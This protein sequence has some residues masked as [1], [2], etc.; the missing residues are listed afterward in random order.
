M[1][2]ATY[3]GN[4]CRNGH[5]G[6]RYKR[7]DECLECKRSHHR[8]WKSSQNGMKYNRDWARK[9]YVPSDRICLTPE[10][11]KDR[12]K[13]REKIAKSKPE[14]QIKRRETSWR[15][16][17]KER[18]GITSEQYQDMAKD[19]CQICGCFGNSKKRLHVDHCHSTG[20]V[21]GV[22]CDPCNRGLGCF[23]DD[24]SKIEKAI[25]YLRGG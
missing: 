7:T 6:T 14:Y 4:P 3:Q 11:I 22:L 16:H 8:Q 12:R 17:L 25:S 21:R 24:I 23:R 2:G 19:G 15:H 13:E 9:K 5:D 1:P 18:Y 10:Q 20:K